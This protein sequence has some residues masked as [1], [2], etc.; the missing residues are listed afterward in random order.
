MAS[1]TKLIQPFGAASFLLLGSASPEIVKN[2][3]ET[4]AGRTEF[5]DLS[6]CDLEEVGGINIEN[7]WFRGGFPRAYLAEDDASAA[8]WLE[9]FTRTFLE[10][11]LPQLGYFTASAE[12]R[13]LWMML[14]SI[15]G[16]SIYED[17][18]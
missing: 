16:N 5:V 11:D 4:L 6:G 9:G 12:M 18:V 15:Q 1:H 2:T 3:S 10:R 7:L 8:A 17:C 13:K 14:A